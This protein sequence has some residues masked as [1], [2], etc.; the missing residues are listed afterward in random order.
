[1][2]LI[3]AVIKPAMLEKVKTAIAAAGVEGATITDVRGFGRQKGKKEVYRG[4]SYEPD[5][6]TKVQIELAVKTEQVDAVVTA[7][8]D[9][10]NTGTIGDGKIFVTSLEQVI[11]IRTGETDLDAI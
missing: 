1:M 2:K 4:K 11:R 3:T 7:I 9:A 10:A 5:L 6:I 8:R